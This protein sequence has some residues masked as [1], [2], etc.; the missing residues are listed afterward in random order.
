MSKLRVLFLGCVI[1]WLL[2]NNASGGVNKW[3]A[4][5]PGGGYVQSMIVDPDNSNIVYA[6]TGYAGLFKSV[7]GGLNW[8]EI[9][10]GSYSSEFKYPVRVL[11]FDPLDST[12]LYT[13]FTSTLYKSTDSGASWQAL[14]S[15][16]S[17]S[18]LGINPLDPQVM[19]VVTTQDVLKTTNGGMNWTP[20]T[21]AFVGAVNIGAIT[22][23][24]FDPVTPA[25]VYAT[26]TTDGIWVSEDNGNTW[27]QKNSG[28]TSVYVN[29]MVID[30]SNNAVV[31]A[32]T[33]NGIFKA[34]IISTSGL[35]S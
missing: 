28:L 5:G 26:S 15:G 20:I 19:F 3:T 4:I 25:K 33:G 32:G 16:A 34:I 27:A 23:V 10:N 31:Y 30:R 9:N 35:R 12:I 6:G 22:K 13:A 7:D 21:S 24:V 8:V 1:F 2:S 14:Y 18:A 11:Q 17:V 29:D